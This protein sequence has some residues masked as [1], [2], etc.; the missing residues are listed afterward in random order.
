METILYFTADTHLGHKNIIRYCKRPFKNVQEMDDAIINNL[1]NVVKENDILWHLGDF[2]FGR[3]EYYLKRIN[4][5]RIFLLM[6]NHDVRIKSWLHRAEQNYGLTVYPPN[7]IISQTL[8][9]KDFVGNYISQGFNGEIVLCHY[10]LRDWNKRMHGAIH[11]HGHDHD[12]MPNLYSGA[13]NVGVDANKFYPV[14]LDII[15]RRINMLHISCKA[16]SNSEHPQ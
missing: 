11:L 12:T 1:N 6:G 15:L 2:C 10:P 14:S 9:I 5:K 13:Y 8:N 3:P 7:A 16:K 4:C